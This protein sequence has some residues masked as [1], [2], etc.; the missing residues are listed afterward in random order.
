MLSL[1]RFPMRFSRTPATIRSTPPAI[2]AQTLEVLNGQLGLSKERIDHLVE[3]GVV[4][5]LPSR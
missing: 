3:T 5:A 4:A 2:G 1:T